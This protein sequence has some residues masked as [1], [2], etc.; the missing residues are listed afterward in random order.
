MSLQH[1]QNPLA[2]QDPQHWGA[3]EGGTPKSHYFHAQGTNTMGG[4]RP[5]NV[6]LPYPQVA[7]L[8]WTQSWWKKDRRTAQALQ[9]LPQNLPQRFQHRR[10]NLEKRMIW[11]TSLA[12]Y[13]PRR[14]P[15][16]GV[17]MFQHHQSKTPDTKGSSWQ[18]SQ[19][20]SHSSV[21]DMWEGLPRLYRPLIPPADTSL[22]FYILVAVVIF[23]YELTNSVG[24]TWLPHLTKVW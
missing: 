19:H 9:R 7:V 4:S 13:D 5:S 24:I 12:K 16:L 14:C 15:P 3:G 11:Q 23:E 6:R 17:S 20:A 22:R 21:S 2:R 1:F 8:W 10:R 18:R